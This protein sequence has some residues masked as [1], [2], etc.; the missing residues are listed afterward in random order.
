MVSLGR[1]RDQ[2]SWVAYLRFIHSKGRLTCSRTPFLNQY[3]A[4]TGTSVSV[5]I[6]APINANDMVSAM[7]WNSFAEGPLSA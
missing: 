2:S 5:R 3:E 1:A 6:S 4:N 7:G